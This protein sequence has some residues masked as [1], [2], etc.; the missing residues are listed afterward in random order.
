MINFTRFNSLIQV[1]KNFSSEKNCNPFLTHQRWKYGVVRCPYCGSTHIANRSDSKKPYR[2][3]KTVNRIHLFE[4]VT[5][6]AQKW[7]KDIYS[8][9]IH[10]AST[11]DRCV[12]HIHIYKY[13]DNTKKQFNFEISL[14][15]LVSKDKITLI[16]QLD[17]EKNIDHKNKDKCSWR[18]YSDIYIM[19]CEIIYLAEFS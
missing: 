13:N 19:V 18:G 4:M 16:R 6:G 5:I 11:A 10:G 2:C 1:V 15:D 9:Q 12:P 8:I 14:I 17:R 3:E 7:G